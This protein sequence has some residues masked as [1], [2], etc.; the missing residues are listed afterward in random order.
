MQSR[1]TRQ[2]VGRY[3]AGSTTARVADELSGPALLLLAM[4]ASVPASVPPVLVASLTASAA[5]GGPVLGALL[6]RSPRPGRFLASCLVLYATGLAVVAAMLGGLA[7]VWLCAI[8]FVAGLAGPAISGGWSSQLGQ[9]VSGDGLRRAT[10]LDATS[11]GFAGL[12]GPGAAGIAVVFWDPVVGIVLLVALLLVAASLALH[13]PARERVTSGGASSILADVRR[14]GRAIVD[15]PGLRSATA[16]SC[17]SY[18]GIGLYGVLAPR[19]GLDRL[20]GAGEGAL[21]LVVAAVGSMASSLAL[22]RWPLPWS[23]HRTLRLATLTAGLGLGLMALPTAS[24]AVIGAAVVGIGDGPALVSL[25][26]IRHR[27]APARLRS[28][29]FTTGASLK[30]TAASV[31][32]ALAGVLVSLPTSA[33]LLVAAAFQVLA[34]T[35]WWPSARAHRPRA[36]LL[37]ARR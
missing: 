23:L 13:L 15:L 11:Y 19:I 34:V 22:A 30:L 12:V 9:L 18:L 4:A 24:G 36:T 25:M 7:P 29:V 5:L 3:L 8:A 28:Q 26:A 37:R 20:G 17:V 35:L 33:L 10:A 27:E 16:V 32:A 14:G 6:D 2:G 1:Y 31:G 21:L